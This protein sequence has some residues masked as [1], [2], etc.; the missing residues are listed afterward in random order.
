M[1]AVPSPVTPVELLE[2][3]L[4]HR[5]TVADI[6]AHNATAQVLEVV[7]AWPVSGQYGPGT[8]VLYDPLDKPQTK[9]RNADPGYRYYALVAACVFARKAEW[10]R[11]ACLAAVLLF[12]AVAA[13][14]AIALAALHRHG[15]WTILT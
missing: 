15:E 3:I 2:N 14:H 9:T 1:P 10:I 6:S 12:P 13:L 4:V 5:N 8:R 11:N 7:C